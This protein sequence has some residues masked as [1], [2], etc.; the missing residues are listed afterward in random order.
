M[1]NFKDLCKV[2][3]ELLKISNKNKKFIRIKRARKNRKNDFTEKDKGSD[4]ARALISCAKVTQKY[5]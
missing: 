4:R 1:N 2:C 3:R 5:K